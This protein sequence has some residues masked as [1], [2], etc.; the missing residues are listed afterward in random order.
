[1]SFKKYSGSPPEIFK[2]QYVYASDI[3]TF[4]KVSSFAAVIELKEFKSWNDLY[5]TPGS[6]SF[7][8][9]SEDT[10]SGTLY[11]KDVVLS[12][13]G[14]DPM[15]QDEFYRL[16]RIPLI[17]L[18]FYQDGTIRVVGDPQEPVKLLADHESTRRTGF[19]ITFLSQ[20]T[21]RSRFLY[22]D[23]QSIPV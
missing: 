7:N 2:L 18:L 21:E 22:P 9:K 16:N 11:K 1:M 5:A 14:I 20:G 12:F 6:I 4:M 3:N 15:A 17:L 23:L 13:P 19:N 8:E 10:P